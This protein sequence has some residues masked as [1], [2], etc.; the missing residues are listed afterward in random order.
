MK[1]IYAEYNMYHNNIDITTF[2]GYPLRIYCNKA[3]NGLKTTH[4]SQYA[5]DAL[6]IDEPLEYARR[7]LEGNMQIWGNAENSL[8]LWQYLEREAPSV[9]LFIL[10]Y[11]FYSLSLTSALNAMQ[12]SQFMIYSNQDYDR[13]WHKDVIYAL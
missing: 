12:N 2:D 9:T 4:C 6:A 13:K 1:F 11:I 10:N 8:G 5:L 3:Q 7:Y